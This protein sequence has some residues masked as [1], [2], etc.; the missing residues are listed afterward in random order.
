MRSASG[1]I[2]R[3]VTNPA[4]AT[5]N[6]AENTRANFVTSHAAAL[7]VHERAVVACPLA[8]VVLQGVHE[9]L[10]IRAVSGRVGC[11]GVHGRTHQRGRAVLAETRNSD[12][13]VRQLVMQ[14]V[15][16]RGDAKARRVLR[17]VR[18]Y[19]AAGPCTAAKDRDGFGPVVRDESL[20]ADTNGDHR[21]E[22]TR[23]HSAHGLRDMGGSR[24][25]GWR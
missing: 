1:S 13:M 22:D 8:G 19:A 16:W 7:H 12:D 21:S 10:L 2:T 9:P 15:L 5:S 20:R 18:N 3:S 14:P 23:Y 11:F 6:S 24:R 4:R 17:V 25:Q